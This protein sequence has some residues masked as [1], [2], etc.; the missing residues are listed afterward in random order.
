MRTWIGVALL[1]GSWPL[2]AGLYCPINGWAWAIC[3]LA[4]IA[5]L[6]DGVPR[7][8]ARQLP[9]RRREMVIAWL[10]V[11]PAAW[12][13][14]WPLR[15][16]PLAIAVGLALRLL[17]IPRRWPGRLGRG[18]VSAGLVLLAQVM[19]TALYTARCARSHELPWP[20][21]QLLTGIA[22]F[23][24]VEATTDAG[25]S[26]VVMHSLRQV[27]GLGATWELLLD[28]ATVCFLV[29]GIVV[30]TLQ[31]RSQRPGG[32]W[33]AWIARLRRF[34]LVFAAWLPVRAGL[35]MSLYLHRA[36]R[37]DPQQPLHVMNVFLSPWVSLLLLIPPLLAAW[38]LVCPPVGDRQRRQEPTPEEGSRARCSRSR[39]T[40]DAKGRDAKGSPA[41]FWRIRLQEFAPALLAA[42]GVGL[43]TAAVQF[44]P[45][46]TPQQGRVMFV[47][48]HSQ[49][50]PT[51]PPY[52]TRRFGHDASYNY[53]AI[54]AYC[55][56]YFETS[57]LL[58]SDRIDAAKLAEC[59][60][61][62]IK[63]PTARYT[64][65]EVR[66]VLDFVEAG[67][68]LL[69][70][71]EHTNF[72]KSGA[73]LNDLARH[74]GF[75]FR[76]DLLLGVDSPYDQLYRAPAVP[77]P[78]VQHVPPMDFAVSCS[79]DPG[80]SRGR[81]V[82]RGT[83]LWSLPV[84]Y[85]PD[86]YFPMPQHQPEMRFG[87][88]I[89]LWSTRHGNGRVLAF[90]DSTIFS[91]F[92]T[93]Q[94]GKAEL[95]RG[96]LDWLNHRDTVGDP[97][98]WLVLLGLLPV[99]AA[100]WMMRRRERGYFMLIAAGLC[101]WVAVSIAVA[102]HGRFWMPAP[103]RVRPSVEVV[104]DRTASDV[105]LSKGAH[106]RGTGTGERERETRGIGYG[107][108]E[109]WI[110][111][112]GCITR[113]GCGD[114]A[115]SGDVLVVICP[116]RPVSGDYL[117]QVDE[118]V[119]HGGKLLVI[120]A[121]QNRQSTANTLLRE[122]ALSVDHGRA[123]S[124]TLTF[125]GADGWPGLD[126]PEACEVGGGRAFAHLDASTPVGTV[127]E[128]GDGLVV[129]L[130]IGSLFDDAGMG[131]VRTRSAWIVQP[132]AEML[133]ERNTYVRYNVQFALFEA[134][135]A[136]ESA[137]AFRPSPFY[138]GRVAV[139]RSVSDVSLSAVDQDAETFEG[140]EAWIPR[141]GY[142]TSRYAGEESI[143]GDALLVLYP[144][145]PVNDVTRDR[146][147]KFVAG[148]GKLLV[149]DSPGN[150]DSTAHELLVPFELAIDQQRSHS[151]TWTIRDDEDDPWVAL[152]VEAAWAIEGGQPF[153]SLDEGTPIG[154]IARHGNG[155]VMVIGFGSELN[156]AAILTARQEADPLVTLLPFDL[157]TAILRCL[158]TDQPLSSCL[159]S[160]GER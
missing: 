116:D 32:R 109:Q 66:A 131:Y 36:A 155:T 123:P 71:G 63:T 76:H 33:T 13:A 134:L 62:V 1:A 135:I 151:G 136:A 56:Q 132:H 29:G 15:A 30:L 88:F 72:E 118:F 59:D 95:M 91:N 17:P 65:A 146:L 130:G 4:G 10:L 113:R 34:A 139:D 115:F 147:V 52:D 152:P 58:E 158:M 69:L 149:V 96:M 37:F 3:V 125:H 86:N 144:S 80:N 117:R 106:I 145:L 26:A 83:G 6:G 148:G 45:V 137:D 102:A 5:L 141:Q 12:Y 156:D 74:L 99:G 16:A 20:C 41:K 24:G 129:A 138:S 100:L 38:W 159:P 11:L 124:G 64:E 143:P 50:E 75:T 94:P 73:Y 68:G 25:G 28:P 101:G 160:L 67:G 35:M 90:G 111:R 46:G 150:R 9:A 120:D 103:D 51:T 78:V 154:T 133:L 126:V 97:R 114:E 57:R 107:L 98:P 81:A 87:A 2:G 60:V 8:P 19:A 39:Q 82:I 127:V 108:F 49:W 27:H 140:F 54:Y 7:L 85:E 23:L 112:T 21:Q 121:P 40:L 47:E 89:E 77:H 18:A 128:H 48:R 55:G 44:D 84:D 42:L 92:C 43:I 122:F 119:R 53:G 31:V 104:V 70:I 153:A 157:Q 79:I 22:R 142:S 110:S 14:P 61:L 105:P 93:F